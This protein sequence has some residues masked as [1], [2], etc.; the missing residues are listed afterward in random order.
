[1]KRL[2][3]HLP[4]HRFLLFGSLTLGAALTATGC[5]SGTPA[6]STRAGNGGSSDIPV[7]TAEVVQKTMPLAISVIGTAEAY[8]NVAVHPQITGELT[9][10]NFKE[11]D[12][13]R[14]GE[15]IFTLDF[16]PL[17][18]ALEQAEAALA[19]DTAQ[20]DNARAS[21]ARYDD[22][23]SRGIAPLEQADQARTSAAALDATVDADRA[24]VE[25]AKV[26]L[27]YATIFAP[28][29]G[30]TG[31]LMVHPGN[32]VRANDTMPLVVIN[33]ISPIYVSFGIP[34]AQL[35]DLKHYLAQG[36]VAVEAAA[37]GVATPSKGHITFIDNAVDPTTG[38][39]KVK[40]S[41]PNDDR[42]LW[43]G[44]FVHVTVTLKVDQRAIVVPTEAV[45][46]STDGRYVFVLKPDRTVD[47]RSVAVDREVEDATVVQSGLAQ[48]DIVV[49][50]G[51][52]R[53]SVG[54]KVTVKSGPGHVSPQSAKANP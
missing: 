25:N 21:A 47:R 4:L 51:Q 40:A 45:Q 50:D 13:I 5:T 19:R 27:R 16:R 49:T 7:T 39:I 38:Q 24:A 23:Q 42:Q 53:L 28:L 26:Q 11:G 6:R 18:S 48:G 29:T 1:M 32:L 36:S 35:P 37:P 3:R 14:K 10:V 44:Q 15:I 41:F 12:D 2:P 17:E 8:S 22:L 31:A 9:S 43:P 20:A 33:Q 52:D 46:D 54:S 34:E 30:R